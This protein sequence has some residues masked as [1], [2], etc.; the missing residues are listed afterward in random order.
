LLNKSHQHLYQQGFYSLEV[1]GSYRSL[2]AIAL[3]QNH[4]HNSLENHFKEL[5]IYHNSSPS[6]PQF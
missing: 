5:E 4:F 1:S 6:V 2:A 3:A